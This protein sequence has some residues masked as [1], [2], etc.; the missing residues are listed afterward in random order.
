M[1][2]KRIRKLVIIILAPLMFLI[3]IALSKYPHL[4]EQYYSNGIGKILRIALNTVS[5]VFPF[6]LAEILYYTL[7]LL[8]IFFIIRLIYSML[9]KKLVDSLLDLLTY[10]SVLYVAFMVLWGFNYNRMPLSYTLNLTVEKSSEN[11][12]YDLCQELIRRANS[13]RVQLDE[14][15]EGVVAMQGNYKDIFDRAYLSYEI[16]GDIYPELSGYYGEPKPILASPLMSYTGITGMYMPYTGEANVNTNI[17]EFTL[18]STATHE[19]AHQRGFARE[20]E[21]N[22]LAYLSCILHPDVDFQY[23]GVMLALSHSLNAMARE[24]IDD[25]AE[26]RDFISQDVRDDLKYESDFW[27]FYEGRIEEISNKVNDSYLKSNGQSA[28]VKSYG[29]MVDLLLAERRGRED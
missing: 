22:Y 19:M 1:R 17:P 13:L 20:D 18:P 23:S 24:N 10:L 3:N 12:L 2:K 6:S 7:V 29:R 8:L 25:Y 14:N 16:L 5:R 4:V 9:K 26:L 15:S 27:R 21:A 28:G 11:E